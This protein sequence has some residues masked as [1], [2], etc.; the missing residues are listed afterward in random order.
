L[1]KEL[2]RISEMILGKFLSGN[3]SWVF[4]YGSETK[5][6]FPKKMFSASDEISKYLARQVKFAS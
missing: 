5:L 4:Q 3:D 6:Q 2:F 1:R